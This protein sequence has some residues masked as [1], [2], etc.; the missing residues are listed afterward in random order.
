MSDARCLWEPP[1]CLGMVIY[2]VFIH[3]YPDIGY[4]YP[5]TPDIH[6]LANPGYSYPDI[7]TPVP[8]IFIPSYPRIHNFVLRIF[9]PPYPGYS[10]P[11]P[12][13]FLPPYPG[14]LKVF[15]LHTRANQ[16]LIVPMPRSVFGKIYTHVRNQSLFRLEQHAAMVQAGTLRPF[17]IGAPLVS[18]FP[19][20]PRSIS[21]TSGV[22]REMTGYEEK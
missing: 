11:V 3:S 7:H 22:R 1:V 18:L 6:T 4:S 21:G 13:I 20:G 16:C 5:R 2:P 9:I 19:Q 14:Y 8:R 12:W 15:T 17:A 10:Y